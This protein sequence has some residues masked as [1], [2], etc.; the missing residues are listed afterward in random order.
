MQQRVQSLANAVPATRC[1]SHVVI[2][3]LIKAAFTI[4]WIQFAHSAGQM[5]QMQWHHC[6][7]ALRRVWVRGGVGDSPVVRH[8]AICDVWL[9]FVSVGE[10]V[11]CRDCPPE[12]RDHVSA[13]WFHRLCLING[14]WWSADPELGDDVI[15]TDR[16]TAVD[17]IEV[18]CCKQFAHVVCLTRSFSSSGVDCP[19]QSIP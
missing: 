15:C 6:S 5:C 7:A 13:D 8:G 12:S 18:L 2:V 3:P 4:A 11:F 14:V 16:M 19:L 1:M 10:E 17:S 9:T